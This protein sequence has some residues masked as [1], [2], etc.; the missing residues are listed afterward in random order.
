MARILER[1]VQKVDVLLSRWRQA[2]RGATD[3]E[4]RAFAAYL[5]DHLGPQLHA[6]RQ[7]ADGDESTV[8]SDTGERM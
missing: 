4:R 6:L 7:S 8:D 5:R 1:D 3:E 2:L